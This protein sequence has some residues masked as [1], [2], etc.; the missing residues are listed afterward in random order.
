[1]Y[2][3]RDD[4]LYTFREV[5]SDLV[6][7][8]R[9]EAAIGDTSRVYAHAP[10]PPISLLLLLAAAEGH[11]HHSATSYDLMITLP[12]RLS[13]PLLSANQFPYSR[14]DDFHFTQV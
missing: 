9:R 13:L 12:E 8:E 2:C 6:A 3:R 1:V 14:L 11:I 7:F 4:V 10:I 5:S